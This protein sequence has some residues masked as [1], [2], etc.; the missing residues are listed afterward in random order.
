M[1]QATLAFRTTD[2]E[3]YQVGDPVF[4]TDHRRD[5]RRTGTIAGTVKRGRGRN[6]RTWRILV[7]PT[8]GIPR[9]RVKVDPA[10]IEPIVSLG[11]SGIQVS[12]HNAGLS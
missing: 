2:P 6:R 5:I 11:A 9:R 1:K 7:A 8:A 12:T 4:W 3:P 10:D